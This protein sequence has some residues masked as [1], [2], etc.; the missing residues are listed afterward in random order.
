MQN[1]ALCF[2]NRALK[3]QCTVDI[4]SKFEKGYEKCYAHSLQL[5]ANDGV[6]VQRTASVN[7]DLLAICRHI[8]GHFKRPTFAC[9]ELKRFLLCLNMRNI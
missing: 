7:D 1:L 6:L 5:V 3:T 2:L 9:G 4:K 8:V